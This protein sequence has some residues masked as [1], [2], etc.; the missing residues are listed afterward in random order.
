MR[1]FYKLGCIVLVT[2]VYSLNGIS[3][4]NFLPGLIIKLNNDTLRGFVNYKNWEKNPSGVSFKIDLTDDKVEYSPLDIKS[5]A[6]K[7]EIYESAIVERESSLNLTGLWPY[8][9][10]LQTEKDTIFLQSIIAGSKSFLYLKDK[11]GSDQYYIKEGSSYTLLIYKRYLREQDGKTGYMENRTFIGQL[12]SYL[13]ECPDISNKLTKTK[14]KLSDFENL[15]A[16]YYSCVHETI[17][18]HK[19]TEKI[20]TELGVMAGTSTATLKFKS[21]TYY[22]ATI[23]FNSSTN[24]SGGMFINFVL[25]RSQRS[26]SLN[27]E[28][29]YSVYKM[30]GHSNDPFNPTTVDLGFGYVKIN[31]MVRYSY[32]IGDFHPFFDIG[33]SN[34]INVHEINDRKDESIFHPN[35][36]SRAVMDVRGHEQG[37]LLGL[38]TRFKNYLFTIRYE[39]S[40]GISEYETLATPTK[41]VYIFLEYKF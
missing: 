21:E 18:F 24:A 5:F 38:G 39:N 32:P 20:I 33:M 23:H 9:P 3:Q 15:F 2:T 4:T 28:L 26:W 1:S 17:N 29:I 11:N 8:N 37:Y 19:K 25:P 14:Y 6:V 30:S 16:N 27:N 13:R 22:L 41:R 34:G 36:V 7:D 40:N 35:K 12:V 10:N 31:N